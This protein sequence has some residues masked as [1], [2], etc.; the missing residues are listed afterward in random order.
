MSKYRREFAGREVDALPEILSVIAKYTNR[1]GTRNTAAV[2]V[3]ASRPTG[4]Y[5]QHC[6]ENDYGSGDNI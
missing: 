6:C 4:F 3:Q 5:N 2:R 1:T